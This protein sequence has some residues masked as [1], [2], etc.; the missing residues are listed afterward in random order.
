M[1]VVQKMEE[2]YYSSILVC[3]IY[4]RNI[5]VKINGAYRELVIG[6]TCTHQGSRLSLVSRSEPTY[7]RMTGT[8]FQQ[9]VLGYRSDTICAKLVRATSIRVVSKCWP[10]TVHVDKEKYCRIY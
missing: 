5:H 10:M 4:C 3:I 2:K 1:H 9:P 8:I 7:S 6:T